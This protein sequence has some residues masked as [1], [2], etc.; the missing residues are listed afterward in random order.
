VGTKNGYQ[1]LWKEAEADV[2]DT[3]VQL[4]FLNDRT[5]YT[6]SSLVTGTAKIF[7]TRSGANDPNFNLRHEPAMIIRKKGM[8]QSFVSIL[9]VHGKF[10]PIAEFSTNA[11]SS[12]S[13]IKLLQND[14]KYSIAEITLGGKK[15]QIAQCNKDF[16]STMIHSTMG[17][18]WV[19]PYTVLYE[20]KKL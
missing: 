10:D 7:F 1:F 9:E 14:E 6:V 15:L 20:G 5:Y 16:D 17:L 13:E 2:K 11:Y 4:T 8:D 12:V 18:N 19:G 3:L